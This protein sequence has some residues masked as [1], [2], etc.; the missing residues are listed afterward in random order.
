MS[1]YRPSPRPTFDVATAIRRA[2]T[3][4]Y[5]WGD[6]ESGEV[7]DWLYVSSGSVHQLVFGLSAG[8]SFRHSDQFRTIFRADEVLCVLSGTMMISHPVTGE[9]RRVET[10]EAVFF[11]RDTWHHAYAIGDEPLRVL[12]F[13]SPPP[14]SGSSG[15]YA[16]SLPLL[17]DPKLNDDTMVGQL[18]PGQPSETAGAFAVIRSSDVRWRLEDG[19]PSPVPVGLYASTEHLTVGRIDLAPGQRTTWRT[20][21][22][23]LCGYVLQGTLGVGVEGPDARRWFELEPGDGWYVPQGVPYRFLA[24]EGATQ[25]MFAVAPNYRSESRQS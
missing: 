4:R 2:D 18:V 19:E 12:E 25:A 1:G 11:R 24:H 8:S 3:V 13:F 9:S 6:D 5:T 23:D 22:G 15:A 16:R 21:G 14:S 10:G 17:T 7:L 20:H